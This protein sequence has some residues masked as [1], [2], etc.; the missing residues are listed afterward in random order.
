[1]FIRV[2][3][4]GCAARAERSR[5]ARCAVGAH[6]ALET[7]SCADASAPV[8]RAGQAAG[9]AHAVGIAGMRTSVFASIAFAVLPIMRF[10]GTL[11]HIAAPVS[12]THLRAHE[13]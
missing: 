11:G 6:R 13:T 7:A 4:A 3:V 8:V 1:M 2:R 10:G 5:Y 12:Y 9:C